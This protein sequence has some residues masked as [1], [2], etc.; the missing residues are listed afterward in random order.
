[1][2]RVGFQTAGRGIISTNGHKSYTNTANLTSSIF[3][4]RIVTNYTN[5]DCGGRV[6]QTTVRGNLGF[7]FYHTDASTTLNGTVDA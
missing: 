6:F 5:H 3:D 4:S 1:M 2:V 7:V